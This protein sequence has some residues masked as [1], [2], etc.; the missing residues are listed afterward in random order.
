M[1]GEDGFDNNKKINYYVKRFAPALKLL[2]CDNFYNGVV[3]D[4]ELKFH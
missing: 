4:D 3:K 2:L 1:S